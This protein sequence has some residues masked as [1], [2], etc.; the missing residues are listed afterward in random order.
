MLTAFDHK[1]CKISLK[2]KILPILNLI[3]FYDDK[4]AFSASL[5]RIIHNKSR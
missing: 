1:Y 3:Y 2:F 4:A 5:L